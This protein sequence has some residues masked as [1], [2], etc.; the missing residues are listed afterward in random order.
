M[1]V[2]QRIREYRRS[3]G[4]SLTA[5]ARRW[6]VSEHTLLL[7]ERDNLAPKRRDVR[8]RIARGLNLDYNTLWNDEGGES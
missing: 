3:Q 1:M 8:E 6:R 4:W 2:G 5:T 7:L